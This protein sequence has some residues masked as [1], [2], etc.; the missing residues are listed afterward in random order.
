[1]A[2]FFY[3]L[4]NTKE[5]REHQKSNRQEFALKKYAEQN[6]LIY[7]EHFIYKEDKAEK[8]FSDRIEWGKLERILRD[9]DTVVFKDISRFTWKAD[10]GYIKYIQ[11]MNK[12]VDL[13][14]LDSINLN[15]NNIKRL[16]E[17]ADR[18]RQTDKTHFAKKLDEFHA[19]IIK[20][21]I[22]SELDRL[23]QEHIVSGQRIKEG[24]KVSDKKPGR[25]AGTMEKMTPELEHDLRLYISD[26]NTLQ[27]DLMKKYGISRNTLKKYIKLLRDREYI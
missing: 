1:M 27:V 16:L 20:I 17:I 24:M 11:L 25:K 5:K 12:G 10:N 19:F 7:D 6:G 9:G 23:E 21:L 2:T 18:E 14:F 8:S 26:G 13:V 3:I 15:T 4:V 22:V